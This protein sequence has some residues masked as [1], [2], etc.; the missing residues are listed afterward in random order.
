MPASLKEYFL[1]DP[2]V[3]FLNHGSFGACPR[4]VFED[5]QR[6]QMELERQPVEF[7][8]RRVTG[9]LAEAR[10]QLAQYVGCAADDLVYFPNPT[11]AINVVARSLDLQPG[12]EVLT[13]D[14]EYG[15]MDRTW[16]FLCAKRGAR[17]VQ[18][19][20]PLP[21]TTP[22]EFVEN[23]WSGVTDRT[24]MIFI[25]QITS[26]TALIFPVEAI[27]KRARERGL[28]TIVDGAHVPGHLPLNLA[29]LGADFYTGA[30]HKWLCAPKGS[31]FLYVRREVQPRLE[32]LVVSWGWESEQPSASPFVDQQEWQGTRDVAAFLATPAAIRFQAQHQWTAVRAHCFALTGETRARVNAI[33]GL[34]PIA[35]ENWLGQMATVALPEM[36]IQ[37]LKTDLYERYRVELPVF[38]WNGQPLLRF[39]FQGYNT[40]ADADALVTGLGELLKAAL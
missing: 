15:A 32:P 16:R 5:Y 4:P 11:S 13:T 1:V 21:M 17:Y 8:G 7:L 2:T 9:L 30:C 19:S 29:E 24:R 18:H 31:S 14:H 38:K 20:F 35:P 12:D 10:A 37:K 39:S 33:T 26:A 36:D 22:E 25:S 34:A 28:L 3:H 40:R 23:F 27:C 6:W